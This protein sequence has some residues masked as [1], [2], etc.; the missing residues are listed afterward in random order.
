[1]PD[2]G[3]L[4]PLLA[5]LLTPD[6]SKRRVM[7][8]PRPPHPCR[9]LPPEVLADWRSRASE[10]GCSVRDWLLVVTC[11]L[12]LLSVPIQG[13]PSGWQ[14]AV[15][16]WASALTQLP[17]ALVQVAGGTSAPIGL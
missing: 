12:R 7:L 5:A 2:P 8:R 15:S 16:R 1:M 14:M 9:K 4:G 13:L 6:P 17:E 11:R 10:E 3:A